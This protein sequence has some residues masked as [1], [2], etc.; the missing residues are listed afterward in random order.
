MQQSALTTVTM[1]VDQRSLADNIGISAPERSRKIT[2]AL[3]AASLSLTMLLNGCP[4]GSGG[5]NGNTNTSGGTSSAGA[6]GSLTLTNAPA[7]TN[8][9]F[10]PDRLGTSNSIIAG[11]TETPADKTQQHS[12]YLQLNFGASDQIEGIQFR[13]NDFAPS[14]ALLTWTCVETD[15]AGITVDTIAGKVVFAGAVLKGEATLSGSTP[16]DPITLNGTLFYGTQPGSQPDN[17]PPTIS[18]VSPAANATDVPLNSPIS[19]TFSEPMLPSS[20][21][22][23][24][25]VVGGIDGTVS[26][27]GNTATFTPAGALLP[28]TTYSPMI[29]TG[30]KDAA[31]NSLGVAYTWSFVTGAAPSG[32]STIMGNNNALISGATIGTGITALSSL[33]KPIEVKVLTSHPSLSAGNAF[34]TRPWASTDYAYVILPVTNTGNETLCFVELVQITYRDAADAAIL[35][36]GIAFVSGSVAKL[37]ATGFFTDTCLSPGETGMIG[38]INANLYAAVAKMEFSFQTSTFAF[39]APAARVIPQSY[40][41]DSITKGPVVTAKNVG[42]TAASVLLAKAYLFDDSNQPLVWSYLTAPSTPVT[43]AATGT[44]PLSGLFY[45]GTGSTLRAFV[46]FEDSSTMAQL[47]RATGFKPAAIDICAAPLSDDEIQLCQNDRRNLQLESLKSF[48]NFQST[49]Q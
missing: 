28:N 48:I 41:I 8:G 18:T 5:T 25:F 34:A 33:R 21:N 46:N 38:D 19:V 42:T 16:P 35:S 43:V 9:T 17:T 1:S 15:C 36:N 22:S 4:S 3:V 26:Y 27:S 6:G 29:T 24:T 14:V 10:V 20:I 30:V 32:N 7:S 31:G 45:D 49:T 12:E 2:S 11:W 13:S 37:N 39:A 23:S 47:N 40:V 44:V